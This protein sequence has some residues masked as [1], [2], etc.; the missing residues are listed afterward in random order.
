MDGSTM[1]KAAAG[2]YDIDAQ[3]ISRLVTI[4]VPQK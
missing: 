1:T 4:L 3:T 2:L